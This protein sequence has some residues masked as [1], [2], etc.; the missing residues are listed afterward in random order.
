MTANASTAGLALMLHRAEHGSLQQCL[1][2]A[3]TA[4]ALGRPVL[5]FFAGPA[6]HWLVEN[7][8]DAAERE[9]FAAAGVATAPELLEHAAPLGCRI[10]LCS[11]WAALE[12]ID[13]AAIEAHW[14]AETV[15]TAG[16]LAAAQGMQVIVL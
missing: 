12:G 13:T 1:S 15:G 14:G 8:L 11:A 4:A 10:L 2:L 16:F 9:R 6:M 5:L 7:R 3:V